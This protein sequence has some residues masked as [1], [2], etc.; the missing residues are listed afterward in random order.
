MK[1]ISH[2]IILLFLFFTISC[3]SQNNENNFA[4]A[5]RQFI[6]FSTFD[7]NIFNEQIQCVGFKDLSSKEIIHIRDF[8]I[9]QKHL[10]G[11]FY[12]TDYTIQ[13]NENIIKIYN[14]KNMSILKN[15]DDKRIFYIEKVEES[16]PSSA[17]KQ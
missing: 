2:L 17:P 16:R 1:K 11:L 13:I 15:D 14:H 5:L 3:K 10:K 7:E 12:N 9:I 4:E 6:D 8:S